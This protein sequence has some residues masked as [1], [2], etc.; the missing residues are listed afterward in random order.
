MSVGLSSF[1]LLKTPSRPLECLAFRSNTGVF[2]GWAFC[3]GKSPA[4]L[5]G[6]S[7]FLQRQFE[8][9]NCLLMLLHSSAD[10]MPGVSKQAQVFRVA[11]QPQRIHTARCVLVLLFSEGRL[12]SIGIRARRSQT[13]H[14]ARPGQDLC[15]SVVFGCKE[16]PR[17]ATR[18]PQFGLVHF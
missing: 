16:Q 6:C 12:G 11:C 15:G 18:P 13:S 8:M 3:L 2:F 14:Q 4:H 5:G 17:K 7:A 10:H 9:N 1:P